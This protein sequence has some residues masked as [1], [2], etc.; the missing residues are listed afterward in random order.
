MWVG[1]TTWIPRLVAL[2]VDGTLLDPATRRIAPAVR[3]A[4]HR[5]AE[6][7]SRV[8]VATG[9]SVL[10]ALPIAEELGLPGGYLLCSNGAVLVDAATGDVESA[11]TFCPAPVVADLT[12]RL[13][14]V[15]F[16]AE[17]IGTGNLVTAEFSAELLHGPQLVVPHAELVAEPI[18][19]LIA[20]W[21][22]HAPGELAERMAGVELPGSTCTLDHYEPWVTVVGAGITKASALEKLRTG[23]GIAQQD[24]FAAGDGDND[25]QMLRWAA[26]GVAMGQAPAAVRATADE[27]VGPVTAD[28]VADA[29]RRWFG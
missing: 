16:A 5:A 12:E 15:R 25:I 28:G 14:G 21:S 29:L 22:D 6:A 7:G 17:K 19:R 3:D 9:R 11:E 24:T 20:D 23:F 8:V 18:P 4:V 13:P 2:D 27:V 10:G 1:V 26:H